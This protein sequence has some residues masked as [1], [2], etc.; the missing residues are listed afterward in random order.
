MIR[1]QIKSRK[2]CLPVKKND[3]P[4]NKIPYWHIGKKQQQQQQ[5]QNP[6]GMA[7]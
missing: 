5:Q 6:V 4:A 2:D 3:S 1:R 7:Y